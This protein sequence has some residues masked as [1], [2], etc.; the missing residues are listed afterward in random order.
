MALNPSSKVFGI[1]L[2]IFLLSCN[3]KNSKFKTI[4]DTPN[5]NAEGFIHLEDSNSIFVAISSMTSPKE[6]YIY[7]NELLKYFS[8]EIGK[9]VLLR[10]RKT[11]N[12][13]NMLL[14]HSKVE[15]AFICTGAYVDGRND[16]YL[17]L[18]VVPVINSQPMY[19]AYIITNKVN[20][21]ERFE[22][23]KGLTFAYTDPLSH[24]GCL[25]PIKRINELEYRKDNFFS[26]T[27]Y[28][29]AHD[30]SIDLIN[31][32]IVSGASIDGLIFDYL[33]E[34]YPEKVKNI[35]IIEKSD[36]FGMPPV[37]VPID[38][39]NYKFIKYQNTLLKMHKS[40][41][42]KEILDQLRI[43]SFIV[44]DDSIYSSAKK[45]KAELNEK[46]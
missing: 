46:N 33:E 45:L 38:L 31:K 6:T 39:E 4:E 2:L 12:E 7:Y 8:E 35:K 21:F 44:A 14:K 5:K 29:Y 16:N 40:I 26:K 23:I 18:L 22:D 24:T 15:F 34:F 28:T 10:Q 43:D 3:I 13:T 41:K 20:D 30:I 32:N 11:Y 1:V 36:Y 42:G 17:K 25:Y 37:V 9:P 27:I 19:Y